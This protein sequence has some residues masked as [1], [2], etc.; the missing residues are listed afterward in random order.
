MPAKA[1]VPGEAFLQHLPMFGGMAPSY[2]VNTV[3]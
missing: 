1:T 2:K 3:L